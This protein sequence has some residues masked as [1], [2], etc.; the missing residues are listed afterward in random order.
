M[1]LINLGAEDFLIERGM[2]IA[3]MVIASVTQVQLTEVDTLLQT[4][5]GTDGFG[6]TG[7]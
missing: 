1:I 3:Q 4:D 5:R 7:A 2:R 6:S